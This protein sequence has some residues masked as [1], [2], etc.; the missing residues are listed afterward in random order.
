MG[1]NDLEGVSVN[2]VT[3]LRTGI[4]VLRIGIF[5]KSLC[6]KDLGRDHKVPECTLF[7]KGD[8]D[9]RLKNQSKDKSGSDL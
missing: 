5:R 3:I 2:K 9:P 4:H 6:G 7:C 8:F 1:M